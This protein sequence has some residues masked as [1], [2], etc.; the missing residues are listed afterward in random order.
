[1]GE[2]TYGVC[3]FDGFCIERGPNIDGFRHRNGPKWCQ[4]Q[5]PKYLVASQPTFLVWLCHRVWLFRCPKPSVCSPRS[6]QK[7]SENLPPLVAPPISETLI[8][9]LKNHRGKVGGLAPPPF[10]FVCF[11]GKGP[12]R[13]PISTISNLFVFVFGLR[14]PHRGRLRKRWPLRRGGV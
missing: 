13:P 2:A 12:L 5:A 4:S 7:P 11:G 6:M 1:M 9:P 14:T 10:P 3:L 8:S